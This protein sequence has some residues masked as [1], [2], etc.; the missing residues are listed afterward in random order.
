MKE[1]NI[2]KWFT[3][4]NLS[5]RVWY[6]QEMLVKDENDSVLFDGQNSQTQSIV[7]KPILEKWVKSVGVV[8][9]KLIITVI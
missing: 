9:N 7:Y 8:D 1:S 2:H 4:K 3:L 6:G 5:N